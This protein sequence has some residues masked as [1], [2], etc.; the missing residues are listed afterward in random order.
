MVMDWRAFKTLKP[1]LLCSGFMVALTFAQTAMGHP[2]H[3]RSMSL[4]DWSQGLELGNAPKPSPPQCGDHVLLSTKAQMASS[5][6]PQADAERLA[7][8]IS[9]RLVAS[10]ADYSRIASDLAAI[11]S[12]AKGDAGARSAWVRVGVKTLILSVKPKAFKAMVAGDYKGLDCLNDWYGGRVV[13]LLTSTDMAIIEF[14]GL[15]YG[16]TIAQAYTSHPDIKRADLDRSI[17]GGDDMRLCNV[18]VGG[19]HRYIFSHGSGDCPASCIQW[20]HKGYE[21]TPQGKVTRRTPDYKVGFGAPE[22]SVSSPK[23]KPPE[24]FKSECFRTP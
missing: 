7:L 17:G 18:R 5:P 8:R 14:R 21:V 4:S 20:I 10:D 11:R 24:W 16:P 13:N 12:F 22:T 9:K 23:P 2:S 15:F 19:A 6:R 1:A 3:A